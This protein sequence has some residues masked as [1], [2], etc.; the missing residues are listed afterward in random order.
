MKGKTFGADKRRKEQS[1]KKTNKKIKRKRR[2]LGLRV[3]TQQTTSNGLLYQELSCN[4][5]TRIYSSTRLAFLFFCSCSIS[6]SRTN[7][8][9]FE[10]SLFTRRHYQNASVAIVNLNDHFGRLVFFYFSWWCC[11]ARPKTIL[12]LMLKTMLLSQ[13]DC[14]FGAWHLSKITIH[15]IRQSMAL[16]SGVLVSVCGGE[17]VRAHPSC[18]TGQWTRTTANN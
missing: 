18:L 10:V 12:F 3:N 13:L 16:D 7:G 1:E 11:F 8:S 6:A 14:L 17:C 4:D 9:E 5:A 2:E 15:R